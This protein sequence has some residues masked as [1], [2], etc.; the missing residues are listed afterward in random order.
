LPANP[1]TKICVIGAGPCGL[2]TLK[3]LS[4]QGLSDITC[5]EAGQEVGGNWVFR[6]PHGHSSVYASAHII[7]SRKRSQFRDFPMPDDY[8]DFPSREEMKAYFDGYAEAFGVKRFVR[9]N[10]RVDRAARGADGRW[11]VRSTGPQGSAEDVFDF[12]LVC[13]GHHSEPRQPDVPGDF[14]GEEL[15]S[16]AYKIAEPFRGKRV[17][18]VGGGNSACDIAA[19]VSRV[20]KETRISMRQGYYIIPK[21]VFGAPVDVMYRRARWMPKPMRQWVLHTGLKLIVG[22]WE[23]YGLKKPALP[24][25]SMHPTLNSE[26]LYLIRHGR[27]GARD[28]V[29]RLDG[30]E[31]VFADGKREAF[32]AIIWATGYRTRFP[33]FDQRFIDWEEALALP[34]YLKMMMADVPNLFFIGLFQPIGC[35]WTLADFQAEIAA[36]QIAGRLKR[37]AD[38]AQRIEYEKRHPHWPFEKRPRHAVEVDYYDFE[39]SLLRELKGA[40]PGGAQT[41]RSTGPIPHAPSPMNIGHEPAKISRRSG[42]TGA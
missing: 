18:I 14:A 10:T 38:I 24:L 22:R 34:L 4:A 36:L 12:L 42:A 40:H 15:H 37:P 20:A 2:T 26:L 31:V 16:H 35:I 8:P 21:I 29:E 30:Q 5:F 3:N 13:S 39:R 27:I 32:D 41:L 11:R 25:M 7:S 9:F 17:L 1:G 23:R 19:D 28:G 33:F 6:D